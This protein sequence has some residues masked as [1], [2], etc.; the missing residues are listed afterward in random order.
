MNLQNLK[1]NFH[2]TERC[3]FGCKFCFAPFES[4][5]LTFNA[6][7]HIISKISE[8]KSCSAINF[9]GGEPTIYKRLPELIRYAHNC[10]LECSLITNGYNLS[11]SLLSEILPY[12]TKIGFSVHSFREETQMAIMSCTQ[13]FDTLTNHRLSELCAQ[14]KTAKNSCKIKLNTIACSLNK[15]EVLV[16]NVKALNVDQWKILR[17]KE[18]TKNEAMLVSDNDFDTFCKN[19]RGFNNTYIEN[20]MYNTYIIVNPQGDLVFNQGKSYEVCGNLLCDNFDMLLKKYPL[21]ISEYN[22][23]E[24]FNAV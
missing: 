1:V 18:N 21:N 6:L 22:K 14:I 11:D 3:N 23:R 9:A 16:H 7:L 19:N 12:V 2:F 10:G 15:N 20:N 4:N 13:S 24:C 5:V 17:C 8:S